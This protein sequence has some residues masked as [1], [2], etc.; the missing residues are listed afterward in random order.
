MASSVAS[1]SQ[2]R[3]SL[4]RAR[5]HAIWL[6]TAIVLC[7]AIPARA[8]DPKPVQVSAA[9]FATPS[10]LV[11]YGKTRLVYELRLTNY[12][13]TSYAIDRLD[14]TAPGLHFSYP[15]DRLE[16]MTRILG[17]VSPAPADA[18]AAGRTAVIYVMLDLAR[19]A[20]LPAIL[21]HSLVLRAPDGSQHTL[22]APALAV[23]MQ[24][25]VV[26]EPPLRGTGW[27]A[28]DSVH[29]GPD[30]AHRRTIFVLDGRPWLA[31]RYAI[32]W[33]KVR[34]VGGKITTCS[35]D[36]SVN[37]SYF[38]YNASVYAVAPGKIVA[39]LDG[40]PENVP[41]AGKLAIGLNA[42]NVAGNHVVEDLGGGRYALYAHLRPGSLT[43]KA[44]D[45]ISAGQVLGKV[46]NSGNSTE[47]HLHMHI[48]DG[49][50]FLAANG[51]PYEFTRFHASGPVELRAA[52]RDRMDFGPIG[53][54][55]PQ[56]DEYPA[57][58][59]EVTFP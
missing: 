27:L 35:G 32:D 18:L 25:P 26:V 57:A 55:T 30:A 39:V 11:Q 13:T 24:S 56:V 52:P 12:S 3:R 53:P 41:H 46:G 7:E 40:I 14:V 6:I 17:V 34:S 49:P 28:G 51:L 47:P 19:T 43:V 59:A 21:H 38:C 33:V 37:T 50:S 48:V 10:P 22:N 36:E 29:N 58:N 16:Q 9:F 23:S 15:H 4:P 42:H 31:Q 44:G 8:A 2:P 5:L 54:L 1:A 20:K 45:R